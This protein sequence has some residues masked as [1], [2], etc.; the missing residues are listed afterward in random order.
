MDIRVVLTRSGL[1][2]D[3]HTYRPLSRAELVTGS[4]S[5]RHNGV[6]AVSV[7][8]KMVL[9]GARSVAE[10]GEIGAVTESFKRVS[11]RGDRVF[12][13]GMDRAERA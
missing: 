6:E 3:T 1:N 5:D 8:A 13:R 7:I 4:C 9:T 2:R 10:I 11:P 12:D